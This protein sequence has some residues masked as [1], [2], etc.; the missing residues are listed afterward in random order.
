M[1]S[2]FRV[3][4]WHRVNDHTHGTTS[5]Q[6]DSLVGHIWGCSKA[7]VSRKIIISH[8][9]SHGDAGTVFVNAVA[10]A[11]AS[12]VARHIVCAI[13]SESSFVAHVP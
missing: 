4:L 2:Y 5:L 1:A 12:E 11:Q 7:R 10:S 6:R 13:P 3:R 8:V 9:R